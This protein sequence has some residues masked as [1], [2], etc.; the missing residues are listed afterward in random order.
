MSDFGYSTRGAYCAAALRTSDELT[1]AF[2]EFR[3]AFMAYVEWGTR[4]ALHNSQPGAEI[5]QEAVD[6]HRSKR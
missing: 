2:T 5:P 6:Q 3:S 1:C 4:L